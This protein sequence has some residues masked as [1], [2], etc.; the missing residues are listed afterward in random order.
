MC[1]RARRGR[2]HTSGGQPACAP[3]LGRDNSTPESPLCPLS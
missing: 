1:Q 2:V 3:L